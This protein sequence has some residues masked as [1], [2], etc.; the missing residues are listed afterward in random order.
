MHSERKCL[1]FHIFVNFEEVD[2]CGRRRS[3]DV[4]TIKRIRRIEL[5]LPSG[6]AEYDSQLA[7]VHY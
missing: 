7:L 3:D 4:G 6:V 1:T 5:Y 2:V